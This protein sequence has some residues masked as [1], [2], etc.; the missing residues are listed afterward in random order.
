M[1][2]VLTKDESDKSGYFLS[3][4]LYNNYDYKLELEE[5]LKVDE[6]KTTAQIDSLQKDLKYDYEYLTSIEP[7]SEQL[8]IYR[9]KENYFLTTQQE[10]EFDLSQKRQEYYSMI[11]DRINTSVNKYGEENQ[12]N[13]IFGANGDG[14]V[15]YADNDKNITAELLVYINSDYAG[16]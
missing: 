1:Y 10:L 4:E 13:F 15:M 7:N 8:N 16:E 5:I 6:S 14:S 2:V 12:Y 11:W 9:Q 3:S